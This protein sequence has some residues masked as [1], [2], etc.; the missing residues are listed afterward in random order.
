MFHL[1]LTTCYWLEKVE[2]SRR[3]GF[4]SSVNCYWKKRRCLFS[5]S[6]LNDYCI[7]QWDIVANFGYIPIFFNFGAIFGHFFTHFYFFQLQNSWKPIF[8]WIFYAAWKS[9]HFAHCDPGPYYLS[10]RAIRDYIQPGIKKSDAF[11]WTVKVVRSSE[12][13]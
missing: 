9:G 7:A 10:V 5:K 6:F 12:G 1:P 13:N 4:N 3:G 11:G 2:S 8:L